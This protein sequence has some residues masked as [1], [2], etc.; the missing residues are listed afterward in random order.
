MTFDSNTDKTCFISANANVNLNIIK[1]VLLKNNVIPIT[2]GDIKPGTSIYEE[3]TKIISDCDFFIA[4]IEP[5]NNS[6][7]L[8]E[9]GYAVGQEKNP[10]I[11]IPEALDP[12]LAFY[13]E[14]LTVHSSVDNPISIDLALKSLLKEVKDDNEYI[15]EFKIQKISKPIGS[16]ASNLLKEYSRL[17]SKIRINEETISN[18]VYH[19]IGAGNLTPI[20]EPFTGKGV[21]LDLI[22][23]DD[24]ISTAY[25]IIIEIKLSVIGDFAQYVHQMSK[26]LLEIESD[27][28]ILIFGIGEFEVRSVRIRPGTHLIFMS[29]E[30]FLNQLR[31]QS[32]STMILK[33]LGKEGKLR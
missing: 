22:V 27:I 24:G 15:Q 31:N 16:V 13:Q 26:Y 33:H 20:R 12:P 29:V 25:P 1:E 17:K 21:K 6:Q 2:S 28:A 18:L 32:F 7:V 9:L 4:V 8:F 5:K 23:W 30:Y 3:I 19:A 11:I 14:F 10:I